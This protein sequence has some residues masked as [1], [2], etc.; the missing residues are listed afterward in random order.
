M[1]LR[2]IYFDDTIWQPPLASNI[3]QIMARTTYDLENV[4]KRAA[5][6]LRETLEPLTLLIDE[7]FNK[8]AEAIRISNGHELIQP[9]LKRLVVEELFQDIFQ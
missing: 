4:L 7:S 1:A 2:S 9:G 3:T 5:G 8:R 6:E